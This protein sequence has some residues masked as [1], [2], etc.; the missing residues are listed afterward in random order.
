M[1]ITATIGVPPSAVASAMRASLAA[2]LGTAA[3]ASAELSSAELVV[4]VVSAPTVA[5]APPLASS[6]PPSPPPQ[7]MPPAECC[8]SAGGMVVCGMM[9]CAAIYS[10]VC[11][12]DGKTYS[13]R[14][15]AE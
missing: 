11:G 3:A 1:I 9:A 5:V 12:G 7:P 15:S 8:D 6:P 10:P 4:E 14:C 13:N 2:R